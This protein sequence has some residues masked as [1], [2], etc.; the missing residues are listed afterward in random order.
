MKNNILKLFNS[1]V[2]KITVSFSVVLVGTLLSLGVYLQHVAKIE[3]DNIQ[4]EYNQLK[5][6]RIQRLIDSITT[7]QPVNLRDVQRRLMDYSK[8]SGANIKLY[9][10]NNIEVF[11]T[12]KGLNINNNKRNPV[13]KVI[14]T[15]L[16]GMVVEVN[17]RNLVSIQAI[18]ASDTQEDQLIQTDPPISNIVNQIVKSIAI[19]G[20]LSIMTSILIIW[21]IS[22][23]TLNPITN[24]V[25]T[26]KY[27]SKGDFTKRVDQS[28]SGELSEIVTAFN[29]MASELQKLDEQRKIMIADIAHELRT[30]MTNLKGYIEGWS[31]GIIKPDNE[32]LQI[33]DYQVNT[34]S[35]I[36][37][38]L[39]T[40]SLAESGMLNLNIS[41]FD[42]NNKIFEIINN[43]KL[44]SKSKNINITNNI[45][46]DI[47]INY[48][49]Q[50]F[51]QI[52]TNILNNSILATDDGGEISF[53][54]SIRKKQLILEIS[55]NGIGIPKKE[56]PYIF[57]RFYR[58]DKS[59]NRQSGGS[60]LG[61]SIV[62][63]LIESHNGTIEINSELTK[64]TQVLIFINKYNTSL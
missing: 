28:G 48:D 6:E 1:L 43:F 53:S 25:N 45:P 2:F 59:R 16:G 38:D 13:F 24:I 39:S 22:R 60:G 42:L 47:T 61:L 31:D 20:I 54:T 19:I 7:N 26:S 52:I 30:P 58:A 33:L 37:D 29:Y 12:S 40:L 4:N 18:S 23:R 49:A 10:E 57:D 50:R 64:G 35:K 63:Y 36:I 17:Q 41:E 3:S 56:L 5:V 14:P 51:T 15:S 34:L 21:I 11:D 44:R 8:I 32:T 55:D 27:L 62:K 46:S 9:D